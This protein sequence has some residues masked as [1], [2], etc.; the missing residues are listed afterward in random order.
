M[1]K[2][3]STLKATRLFFKME[4][5]YQKF[6]KK[7]GEYAADE[8]LNPFDVLVQFLDASLKQEKQRAEEANKNVSNVVARIANAIGCKP[9]DLV[10]GNVKMDPEDL[11]KVLAALDDENGDDEPDF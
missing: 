7:V 2:E 1:S 11:D 3:S 9:E 4:A 8:G 10:A 5:E 6:R